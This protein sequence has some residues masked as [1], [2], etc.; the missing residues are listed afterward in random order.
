MSSSIKIARDGLP[1]ELETALEA[2]LEVGGRAPAILRV[3]EVS[4]YTDWVLIVS[5]RIDRQVRSICD[6]VA[7]ALKKQGRSPIG[8]DGTGEGLWGLLDYDDFIVHAFYHPVR[9]YYDLESMWSDAPRVELGLPA[10]IMNTQD[11]EGLTAPDVMP[12]YRGDMAFGGFEDEFDEEDDEPYDDEE[13][14][15]YSARSPLAASKSDDEDDAAV[16]DDDLFESDD[17]G[18]DGD[19]DA[20]ADADVSDDDLFES[21]DEEE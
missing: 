14:D 4:G 15:D 11:L 5:G 10:D 16:S 8:T 18:D 19:A 6:A 3:T 2:A 1:P 13:E 21:D 12:D 17:D 9:T 7:D 20:D